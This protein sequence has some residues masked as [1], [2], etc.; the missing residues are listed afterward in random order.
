MSMFCK[1]VFSR[2]SYGETFSILTY[3]NCINI[4]ILFSTLLTPKWTFSVP[5]SILAPIWGLQ[6]RGVPPEKGVPPYEFMSYCTWSVLGPYE[7]I[8]HSR[9]QVP[10]G[11][12]VMGMRGPGPKDLSL[13]IHTAQKKG[14]HV[15]LFRYVPLIPLV[16]LS[17]PT[18]F[19]GIMDRNETW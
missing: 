13:T 15:T 14:S 1:K 16:T 5:S 10:V 17:L 4:Y 12:G 7:F 6:D 9:T 8:L 19:H 3:N 18:V 2:D 11:G